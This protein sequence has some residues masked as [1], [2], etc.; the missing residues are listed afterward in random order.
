[1]NSTSET[2]PYEVSC[3]RCKVTFPVGTRHCIHCGGPI[4][5]G[6]GLFAATVAA[7]AA[8]QTEP[9]EF[10]VEEELPRSSP[11]TPGAIVWVL[12]AGAAAYRACSG[13]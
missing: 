7:A 12:I 1:M 11:F 5:R 9:V 6:R 10:E 13:G 2:T 4:A 8:T 3:P